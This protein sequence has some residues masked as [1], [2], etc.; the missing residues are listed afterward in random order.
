MF[1]CLS[2]TLCGASQPA[3]LRPAVP[4]CPGVGGGGAI[5]ETKQIPKSLLKDPLTQDLPDWGTGIGILP[6]SLG[7][8]FAEFERSQCL[9]DLC[10]KKYINFIQ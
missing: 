6:S 1:T 3:G 9:R 10:S 2:L 7:D 5:W 4:N 8:S